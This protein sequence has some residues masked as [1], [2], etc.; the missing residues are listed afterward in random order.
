MKRWA[1]FIVIGLFV[2][3]PVV[4]WAG[5]LSAGVSLEVYLYGAGRL[6]ALV[7]FVFL[8]F[9]FV[10]GGHALHPSVACCRRE[11]LQCDMI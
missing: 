10:L 5:T 8:F 11:S 7:G 9:Q 3:V 4:F 1:L 2:A 6:L